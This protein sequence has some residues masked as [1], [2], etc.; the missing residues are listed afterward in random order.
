MKKVT[1][2]RH[3]IY[4]IDIREGTAWEATFGTRND[5]RTFLVRP[6]N[7]TPKNV[8]GNLYA[9]WGLSTSFRKVQVDD[10]VWFYA[11]WNERR[12]LAV[13]TVETPP[14]PTE[15]D[16]RYAGY[17]H[18]YVVWI[19]IDNLLT[20]RLQETAHMIKYSDFRQ[21]VPG[22]VREASPTTRRVLQRFL[23]KRGSVSA[24]DEVV[25]RARVE[26][27]QRL[28]QAEFRA[29]VLSV[30]ASRCAISGASQQEALIAAHIK[31]VS[32]GGRHSTKNALLLRADLHNLFD[33]YL[34]SID[35]SYRVRVSTRVVDGAIRKL[36]G[37]R[38]SLPE[39]QN[40][41]PNPAILR[42]HFRNFLGTQ[43]I[44]QQ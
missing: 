31:P 16:P 40:A 17:I 42:W 14:T 9:N 29:S 36:E 41:R 3:W 1:A 26:V 22:A 2:R 12:I 35:N 7:L 23:G 27:N 6:A 8:R 30:Y 5:S 19:K 11:G 34:I 37:V 15:N 39:N 24:T 4:P 44:D 25:R 10:Y 38:V 28:G 21:W 18:S 13:G 33:A 20:L 43:E 32:A